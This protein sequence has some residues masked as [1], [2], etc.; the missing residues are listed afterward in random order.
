MATRIVDVSNPAAVGVEW[1]NDEGSRMQLA[2]LRGTGTLR[3][4]T[5][6]DDG[7]WHQTTVTNPHYAVRSDM[8]KAEVIRIMRRFI[9]D[10]SD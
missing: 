1:Q 5:K 6:G 7:R 3:F 8:R 4:G 9:T 2:W 10:G